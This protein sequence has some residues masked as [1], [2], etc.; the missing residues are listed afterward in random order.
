MKSHYLTLSRSNSSM[1][2]MGAALHL[3]A[4]VVKHAN[5][6]R[7]QRN[8]DKLAGM[9]LIQML[10]TIHPQHQSTLV[11]PFKLQPCSA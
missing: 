5:W 4:Y 9:L 1:N 2:C 10:I 11:G 8:T 6:P 3:L 7:L